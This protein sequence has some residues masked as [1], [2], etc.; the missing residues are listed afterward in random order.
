[1]SERKNPITPEM[2]SGANIHPEFAVYHPDNTP[3][4][5]IIPAQYTEGN[6]RLVYTAST[7]CGGGT[8]SSGIHNLD[9]LHKINTQIPVD[10]INTNFW[11]DDKRGSIPWDSDGKP[12]P[13]QQMA[14]V[15][16]GG[17]DRSDKTK[18][19]KELLERYNLSAFSPEVVLVSVID[20]TDRRKDRII[21]RFD[22]TFSEDLVKNTMAAIENDKSK[23]L[24]KN[25]P[26]SGR[27]L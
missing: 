2:I 22:S 25:P 18:L 27:S 12:V 15:A 19:G 26:K 20:P 16:R 3:Y 8:G 6:Y 9:N 1:M 7:G 11:S 23:Q 5:L 17:Q 21:A 4:P 14:Y 10:Y 13:G 24:K